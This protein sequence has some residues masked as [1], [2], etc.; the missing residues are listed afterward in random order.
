MVLK[1]DTR[2]S[3]ERGN[4]IDFT[5]GLGAGRVEK[6]KHYM[7]DTGRN[8]WSGELFQGKVET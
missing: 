5:G 3:L 4:G 7:G 6:R 1:R 2:I 8:Y